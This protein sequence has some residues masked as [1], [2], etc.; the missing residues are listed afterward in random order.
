MKT[1]SSSRLLKIFLAA[2]LPM[3]ILHALLFFLWHGR[4]IE[5]PIAVLLLTGVTMVGIGMGILLISRRSVNAHE[6]SSS[7]HTGQKDPPNGSGGRQAATGC[8]EDYV[9]QAQ[10]DLRRLE[11]QLFQAQKMEAIGTLAGGIAHDFNNVL[12]AIMGYV[13]L[14]IFDAD[15]RSKVT[16]ELEQILK[17][18]HRAKDLVQQILSYSRRTVRQCQPM[19]LN[20]LIKEA[21]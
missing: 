7:S 5:P 17:A 1:N 21:L 8:S 11:E 13:E 9:R 16:F 4:T 20:T 12:A 2:S 6:P 15:P 3:P 14:A 18:T 10:Q 19:D